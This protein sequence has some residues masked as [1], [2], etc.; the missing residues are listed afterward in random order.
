MLET[1]SLPISGQRG[2]RNRTTP[3]QRVRNRP[4]SATRNRFWAQ[5]P[6]RGLTIPGV[7]EC[8]KKSGVNWSRSQPSARMPPS[9]QRRLGQDWPIRVAS[10]QKPATV[11]QIDPTLYSFNSEKPG[12]LCLFGPGQ[13]WHVFLSEGGTRSGYSAMKDDACVPLL[14]RL[15]QLSRLRLLAVWSGC[16]TIYECRPGM[17][18]MRETGWWLA[19]IA[20]PDSREMR[21][22]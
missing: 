19:L 20:R 2:P 12:A 17:S 8:S 14:T 9:G 16:D 10:A 3:G 1:T 22:E 18:R 21:V 13:S 4:L 5:S 6:A 15:F 7:M 11:T